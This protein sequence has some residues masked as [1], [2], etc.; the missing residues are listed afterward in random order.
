MRIGRLCAFLFSVVFSLMLLGARP[1]LAQITSVTADQAPPVPGVGHDYIKML[2]ETVNP[3]TGSVSITIGVPVPKARGFSTP[4]SFSY[5][6]NQEHHRAG[7][8]LGFED[9]SSYLGKGGW[10]Y[11]IPNLSFNP[12]TIQWITFRILGAGIGRSTRLPG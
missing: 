10:S 12:H 1:A 11:V 8:T 6:S 4:F 2:N 9:N 3:A 7:P 5:N